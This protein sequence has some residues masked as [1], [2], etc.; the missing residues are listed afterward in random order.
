MIPIYAAWLIQIEIT[1]YCRFKCAYCTRATR[2][3]SEH[4]FADLEFVE[5]ALR[6]LEG[7]QKGVG[8]MGG[9]PTEHPQFAEICQ[10]YRK[11]FPREQCGLWTGGGPLFEKYRDLIDETFGI[12]AFNDRA[13]NESYHR[14][15]MI[16]SADVIEDE[17]LRK[18]L[19][20]NCWLQQRW[21]P[22]VTYKGCFFC[23]V[24][25]AFDLLFEGEN[26]YDIEPG[27][28]NKTPEQFR[29]QVEAYCRY[30]SIALPIQSKS[31]KAEVE[32]VSETNA[33]RLIKAKSPFALRGKISIVKAKYSA[34]DVAKMEGELVRPP[35]YPSNSHMRWA[36]NESSF[37]H[38]APRAREWQRIQQEWKQNISKTDQSP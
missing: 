4:Y 30:C 21:S 22:S 35:Y 28:W 11:H 3:F 26:G 38:A 32:S 12:I 23:E 16:A 37:C 18:Q 9:E 15:P 25:G 1:N 2:H 24:A 7:W 29:D 27:W 36:N 14:P 6:S 19:V 5:R 33:A 8:C 10:L 17:Q 31:Y 34:E 20:D 13:R